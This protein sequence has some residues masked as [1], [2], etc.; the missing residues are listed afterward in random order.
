MTVIETVKSAVG[1]GDARTF[2]SLNF[3]PPSLTFARQ[4][5]SRIPSSH[6]RRQTAPR[7]Q[8]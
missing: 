1:L 2:L 7:V 6:E 4:L 3:K 5:Y 8:R